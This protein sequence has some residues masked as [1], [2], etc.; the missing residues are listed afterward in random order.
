MQRPMSTLRLS[1]QI[2]AKVLSAG[3]QMLDDVLQVS[4][5][6]LSRETGLSQEEALE[7]LQAARKERGAD[8][9][10]PSRDGASVTALDL[11]H[12]E[13][14]LNRIVTFSSRLDAALGG[15]L[16]L[17]KT[18]EI[19]GAP[20]VGKTQ[21]CLQLAVDVQVPPCF[22]GLGGQVVFVD[23][24]GSFMVQRV[25]D[26][27][28]AAV[29]HCNLL[30]E[31][32]EQRDAAGAFTV[33]RVLSNIFLVRCLD[34]VE[35]LA[36]IYLLPDFLSRN[37]KVR[38]LVIDSVAFP[39]R[40]HF[41]EL[42]SQRTRLLNGLA[43]QLIALA[44][45]H[46]VAVVLSNQMTTRLHG[47]KSQLVPALGESWGH[48]PTLRILLRWA[49]SQ[50]QA[51]IVKSPDNKEATVNYQI[52]TDGFRDSEQPEQPPSKRTRTLSNQRDVC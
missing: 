29:R 26:L 24:E 39:F 15:G 50:R 42:R 45:K 10:G 6:Q 32:A 44:T 31:D 33:E 27:A 3:F 9:A 2:Q 46:D 13:E 28:A 52:T 7:V 17:G 4:A 1:P 41:N 16:P 51:A 18:T 20:G 35:L 12:K 40:L 14:S 37:P 43:Q 19:C 49:G 11:L 5:L 30:A 34:Y 23:T 36:E 8:E 22:G 25:T 21:L 38:L 47:G 48:A